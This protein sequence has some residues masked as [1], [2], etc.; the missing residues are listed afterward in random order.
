MNP[1]HGLIGCIML[2]RE[3]LDAAFNAY[4]DA[5][6]VNDTFAPYYQEMYNTDD[7]MESCKECQDGRV[8]LTLDGEYLTATVIKPDEIFVAGYCGFHGPNCWTK[9]F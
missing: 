9:I 7:G 1:P 2:C 6:E 5:T 4:G 8:F 3:Y